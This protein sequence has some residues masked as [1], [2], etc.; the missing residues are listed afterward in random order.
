MLLH[1]RYAGL[2]EGVEA[3][4]F[5]DMRQCVPE[6]DDALLEAALLHALRDFAGPVLIGLRSGHVDPPHLTHPHGLRAALDTIDPRNPFLHLLE[7][8]VTT[9]LDQNTP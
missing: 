1:L 2:L 5:G 8:A 4:V 7:S 3:I 6:S 9:D